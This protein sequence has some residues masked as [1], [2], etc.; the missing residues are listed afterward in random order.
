MPRSHATLDAMLFLGA[1]DLE[2]ATTVED[3]T[4]S[5]FN[6]RLALGTASISER[7]RGWLG[8]GPPEW[9]HES[10]RAHFGFLH[11]MAE[12]RKQYPQP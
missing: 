9:M 1:A 5:M 7:L 6:T 12:A 11:A 2:T 4:Q 10:A 8:L 3:Y